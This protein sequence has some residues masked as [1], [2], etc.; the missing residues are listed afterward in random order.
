MS[1]TI[2]ELREMT[3]LPGC[4]AVFDPE[5]FRTVEEKISSKLC[6]SFWL[7]KDLAAV[8]FSCFVF[9]QWL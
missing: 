7:S 5:D 3:K 8:T 2:K 6:V 1:F 4:K 9:C